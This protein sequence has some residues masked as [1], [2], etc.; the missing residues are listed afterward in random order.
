[1]TAQSAA[2]RSPHRSGTARGGMFLGFRTMFGK[3]L[4]RVGPRAAAA[5]HRGVS[6]A[7][8]RLHDHDPVHRPSRPA[9]ASRRLLSHGPDRQRAARLGRPTVAVDRDPRD[10]EPH[11]DRTGPRHARPGP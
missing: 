4:T 3:E 6:I 2:A 7:R 10:D 1:M 8:G 5:D 9:S 11:L